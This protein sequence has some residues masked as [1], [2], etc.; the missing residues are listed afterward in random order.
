MTMNPLSDTASVYQNTFRPV[1]CTVSGSVDRYC[2]DTAE[3]KK[4][5]TR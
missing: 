1:A 4:I 5:A 3:W 2:T